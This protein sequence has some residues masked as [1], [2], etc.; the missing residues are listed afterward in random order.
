MPL[1]QHSVRKDTR[2]PLAFSTVSVAVTSSPTCWQEGGGS[3]CGVPY[4]LMGHE[5]SLAMPGLSRV[6]D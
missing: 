3:R 4:L 6:H 1:W 5:G 2:L